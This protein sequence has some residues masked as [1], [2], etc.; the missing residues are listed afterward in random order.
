MTPREQTV[1]EEYLKATRRIQA[2]GSE[3]ETLHDAE[4]WAEGHH[5]GWHAHQRYLD[6]AHKAGPD[7]PWPHDRP[8]LF[9]GA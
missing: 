6:A 9:V 2:D 7:I 5:A 3:A 4:L 8:T 1:L